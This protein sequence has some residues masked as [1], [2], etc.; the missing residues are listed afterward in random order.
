M[1]CVDYPLAP[2]Q[3]F[4]AALDAA[5]AV[6]K[7]VLSQGYRPSNIGVLGDSV[8]G[9]LAMALL[10]AAAREGLQL[11]GAVG[12]M[13]PR[14]EMGRHGDTLTTLAGE[15]REWVAWACS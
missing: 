12:L 9:N 6:Y 11:P 5:L 14:L 4:P 7:W 3:P 10:L 15:E 8:G 1:L 13:S 2:E